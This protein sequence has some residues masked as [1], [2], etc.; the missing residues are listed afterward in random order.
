MRHGS[1]ATLEA[2]FGRVRLFV[3]TV[4]AWCMIA[5]GM[6]PIRAQ[7]TLPPIGAQLEFTLKTRGPW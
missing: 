1:R 7:T 5:G 6:P 3:A 4:L 2:W